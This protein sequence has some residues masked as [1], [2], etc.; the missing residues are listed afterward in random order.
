MHAAAQPW[1]EQVRS[2]VHLWL[3]VPGRSRVRAGMPRSTSGEGRRMANLP[4]ATRVLIVGAHPDDPDFF[5]GGTVARWTAAGATVSY[6]VVTSGDK[7][8]P[9]PSLDP[10]AFSRMRAA[11]QE[12]SARTLG[13][14]HVTFLRLTDGE[15]V[16]TLELRAL[17]PA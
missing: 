3:A 11:E 14:T 8:M 12:A 2:R 5:C 1:S 6:V 13:V 9:D 7:G 10:V 17:L 4:D 15:V 16:D